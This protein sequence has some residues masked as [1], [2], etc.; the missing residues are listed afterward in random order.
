MR[1]ESQR[2]GAL[3]D[4]PRVDAAVHAIITHDNADF[5][6]LACC[7]AARLLDPQA[8]ILLPPRVSRPVRDFLALHRDRLEVEPFAPSLAEAVTRLT[9]V[10]VRRRSR[11]RGYAPLIARLDA[12]SPRIPVTLVDHHRAAPDDLE[13]DIERI[14]PVGCAATLFV[15]Q[16]ERAGIAPGPLEA[17]LLAL[18]IHT[19]TGSLVLP[20]TT[21]RDVRAAAWTLEHGANLA[22]VRRYLEAPFAPIQRETLTATLNAVRVHPIGHT[23]IGIACVDSAR[24]VPD[25]GSIV[26]HALRFYRECAALIGI[27]AADTRGSFVIGRSRAPYI[28]VGALLATLGGGG[29]PGAAAA[30]VKDLEPSDIAAALLTA[31]ER[32]PPHPRRVADVMSSPVLTVQRDASLAELRAELARNHITGMP[33]VDSHGRMVGVVSRRDLHS[34]EHDGRLDL[35]VSS[36]MAH[37]LHTTTMDATLDEA[38]DQMTR[39]D[40][41]RLPVI[42]RGRLVGIVTRTDLL[43]VLYRRDA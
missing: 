19:D 38:L 4:L 2:P 15:E 40:V 32:D 11:L 10:D 7:V 12:L 1:D 18:G 37:K 3:T 24:D 31:L 28:D 14:E 42:R 41:G 9:V 8:R 35:P 36:C 22:V 43:D 5:D 20:G 29:H 39:A 25:L 33:V 26:G 23:S 17:T 6:A 30:R 34:A 13:G 27:F 16:L 21:A